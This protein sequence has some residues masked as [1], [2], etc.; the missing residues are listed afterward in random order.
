LILLISFLS[1]QI[2]WKAALSSLRSKLENSDD[3]DSENSDDS[4]I[5]KSLNITHIKIDNN[6]LQNSIR[7]EYDDKLREKDDTIDDL[8]YELENQKKRNFEGFLEYRNLNKEFNDYQKEANS[9]INNLQSKVNRYKINYN[10]YMDLKDRNEDLLDENDD[11][12]E[13]INRLKQAQLKNSNN[14]IQMNKE[15]NLL[16]AKKYVAEAENLSKN[17]KIDADSTNMLNNIKRKIEKGINGY[18]NLYVKNLEKLM[19]QII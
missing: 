5:T 6:F 17:S 4:R 2:V 9:V 3:D 1:T 13:E 19:S 10:D 11:L 7:D 16:H 14:M 15:N 18:L 12:Y 8:R